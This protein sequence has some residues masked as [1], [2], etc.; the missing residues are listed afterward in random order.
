MVAFVQPLNEKIKEISSDELFLKK[1]LT[2]GK[3]KAHASA[4]KTVKEVREIMGI[5]YY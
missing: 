3:E 1:V 5:K 2:Q 4:S